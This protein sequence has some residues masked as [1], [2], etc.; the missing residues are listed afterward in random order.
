VGAAGG[1]EGRVC[2]GE[3]EVGEPVGEGDGAAEGENYEVVSVVGGEVAGYVC[4]GVGSA[5]VC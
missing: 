5:G 4:G 3:V 2:E 1:A